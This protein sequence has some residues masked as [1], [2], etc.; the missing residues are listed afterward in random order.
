MTTKHCYLN[1]RY[2]DCLIAAADILYLVTND[3][4]DGHNGA[5]HGVRRLVELAES[6]MNP[7]S[8]S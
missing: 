8:S 6:M 1:L 3:G 7:I 5:I 2:L 4:T